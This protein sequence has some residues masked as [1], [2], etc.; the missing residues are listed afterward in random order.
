[1]AKRVAFTVLLAA[2]LASW[3]GCGSSKP[4]PQTAAAAKPAPSPA[5]VQEESFVASGPIV[6]ENQVDVQAQREG[7]VAKVN[8]DAGTMVG[9]GQL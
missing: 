3:L 6:V 4:A 5:P 8:V 2:S 7:I 9:K 1:M